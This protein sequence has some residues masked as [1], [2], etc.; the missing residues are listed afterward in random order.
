MLLRKFKFKG[1]VIVLMIRVL[2]MSLFLD[3]GGVRRMRKVVNILFG[4]R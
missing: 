3:A 4:S 1:K 2:K